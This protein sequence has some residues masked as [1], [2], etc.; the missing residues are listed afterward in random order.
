[1]RRR[2]V[3]RVMALIKMANVIRENLDESEAEQFLAL[4]QKLRENLAAKYDAEAE[5]PAD[6]F[7][8][9][10]EDE[11]FGLGANFD[12]E[13]ARMAFFLM[14]AKK[15]DLTP[16]QLARRMAILARLRERFD[17]DID[18]E[19]IEFEIEFDP[20][21]AKRF[22]LMK[23]IMMRKLRMLRRLAIA[24][25]MMNDGYD[26]DYYDDD[27]GYD[28][29]DD[30]GYDDDYYDDDYDYEIDPEVA[31]RIMMRLMA[32]RRIKRAMRRRAARRMARRAYMRNNFDF[33]DY[34]DEY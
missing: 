13:K 26:D 8:Y 2:E 12:P 11:D 32:R 25:N 23:A 1:M 4:A 9:E 27:Y 7:G 19:N 22:L 16:E 33:D 15:A 31:R 3:L 28:Y 5:N 34:Y 6:G 10:E 21:R 17:I 18:P 20:Q 30:Y 24:R 29:D 14:H